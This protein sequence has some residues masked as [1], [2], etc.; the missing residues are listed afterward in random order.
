MADYLNIILHKADTSSGNGGTAVNILSLLCKIAKRAGVY[1][2]CYI[3]KGIDKESVPFQGG[4]FAD[5]YKGVYKNQTIC[6]KVFRVFQTGSDRTGILR[7]WVKEMLLWANLLHDNVLP[8]YG[9]FRLDEPAQRLCLVSPWMKNGNLREYLKAQPDAPRILLIRDVVEGLLHLHRVKIVHGDLKAQNIL[10]SDNGHALIAD[11]GLS[12][13]AMTA[14]RGISS[15]TSTGCTTHWAAPELLTETDGHSKPTKPSDVWSFGCLCL[16]IFTGK[17]PFYRCRESFQVFSALQKGEEPHQ[18]RRGDDICKGLEKWLSKMMFDCWNVNPRK[19]PTFEKIQDT[20]KVKANQPDERL[21]T[22]V[23]VM[24]RS[25]FWED[26]R[27]QSDIKIDSQRVEQ[28]LRD[29]PGITMQ[30]QN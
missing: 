27:A 7:K 6:L 23:Q 13:I 18:P 1:P 21:K 12:T 22:P 30:P 15:G 19:R 16:E 8:F 5:I 29:F 17:T 9:V 20:L 24:D 10:V 2:Q 25:A 3:L 28:M 11:F 26:M 4:G 14:T